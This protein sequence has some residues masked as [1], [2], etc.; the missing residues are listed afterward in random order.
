MTKVMKWVSTLRI[1][2]LPT[3]ELWTSMSISIMKTL[4]Y[5]SI[6][7]TLSEVKC[8]KIVKPIYDLIL[9]RYRI[10]KNIP[11]ALK[12]S[13]KKVIGLGLKNLFYT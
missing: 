5:P 13:P 11:L 9:P 8:N 7:S 6:V 4:E 10:C 12:Y 2:S 3:E 1:H